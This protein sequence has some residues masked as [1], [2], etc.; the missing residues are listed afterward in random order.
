MLLCFL[1]AAIEPRT[2]KRTRK[3][4]T[5]LPTDCDQ[6]IVL[7]CARL[8]LTAT[9]RLTLTPH[10]CCCC[11]S[12]LSPRTRSIPGG[13]HPENQVL[14]TQKPHHT[15]PASQTPVRVHTLASHEKGNHR[16]PTPPPQPHFSQ[17]AKAA[18]TAPIAQPH[19]RNQLKEKSTKNKN[20]DDDDNNDDDIND[21]GNDDD[22]DDDDELH[23][24]PA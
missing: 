24:P 23:R 4:H 10:A 7:T 8:L 9:R 6:H 5:L 22:D 15:L 20:N 2:G 3:G 1:I 18:A 11:V 17:R 12:S 16:Q 19:R 14:S 13:N 21:D